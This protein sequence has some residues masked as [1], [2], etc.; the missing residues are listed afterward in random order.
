MMSV[1]KIW[2]LAKKHELTNQTFAEWIEDEKKLYEIRKPNFKN[3]I[4]FDTWLNAR[5]RQ[6]GI[7]LS[8]DSLLDKALKATT[9]VRD[10]VT[11]TSS[12]APSEALKA[13]QEEAEKA[14]L[15]KRIFGLSPVAFYLMTGTVVALTIYGIYRIVKKSK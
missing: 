10:I 7:D 5:Y 4:D 8:A 2:D 1:S 6:K 13:Q 14:K 3:K 12:S 11:G 9:A 15:D